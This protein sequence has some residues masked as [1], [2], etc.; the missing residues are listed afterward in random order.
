L[1]VVGEESDTS[2]GREISASSK[3]EGNVVW[4]YKQKISS[5]VCP[6]LLVQT[7]GFFNWLNRANKH[8]KHIQQLRL[9]SLGAAMTS[10]SC[11]SVDSGDWWAKLR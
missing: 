10:N 2:Y 9:S 8:L 5:D 7:G 4:W 11:V 1:P 3:A 6:L